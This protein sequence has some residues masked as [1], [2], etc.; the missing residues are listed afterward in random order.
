[1]KH[2][3]KIQVMVLCAVL[4]SSIP[5]FSYA[6]NGT[7]NEQEFLDFCAENHADKSRSMY[8]PLKEP[9]DSFF[10]Y[11]FHYR[12]VLLSP[13]G[14][15]FIDNPE[16]IKSDRDL[17]GGKI[18]MDM[19]DGYEVSYEYH[20]SDISSEP[21]NEIII[22]G[23][24]ITPYYRKVLL[25]KTDDSNKQY[26][27]VSNAPEEVPVIPDFPKDYDWK[28]HKESVLKVYPLV[29]VRSLKDGDAYS[30][31]SRIS[32]VTNLYKDKPD[33]YF[34]GPT[35]IDTYTIKKGDTLKKIAESYYGNSAEYIYLLERNKKCIENADLIYPGT[36]IVIPDA[37]AIVPPYIY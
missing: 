18:I 33:C 36:L 24:T 12:E 2:L 15:S 7:L 17:A 11:E 37:K 31:E 21:E 8:P 1:M 3:D 27:Y 4:F 34:L 28:K 26:V 9:D 29:T 6:E 19:A 23:K 32:Y 10:N 14:K 16:E 35:D 20:I 5:F 13:D 25:D 22:E 30:F